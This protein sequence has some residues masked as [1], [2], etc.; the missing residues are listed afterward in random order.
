MY[1]IIKEKTGAE[2]GSTEK[3]IFI[4]KKSN[5]CY[6]QTSEAEAQGIAF[7]GTPYN[8]F[9]RKGVGADETV[10]LVEFDGGDAVSEVGPIGAQTAHN[11]AHIDY[12]SMMSGIDLPDENDEEG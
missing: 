12:L 6:V 8:L 1:R 11:A 4:R 9:G 5:G 2:V 7:K 3:P 10:M